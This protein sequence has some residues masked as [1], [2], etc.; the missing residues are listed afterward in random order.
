MI[1]KRNHETDKQKKVRKRV[2]ES[3]KSAGRVGK[4]LWSERICALW[5][6]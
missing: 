6:W 4:N 5:N 1:Q 3:V 2:K